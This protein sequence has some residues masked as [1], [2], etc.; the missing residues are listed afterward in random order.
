MKDITELIKFLT[1]KSN[2][3]VT[4]VVVALIVLFV[5][6][7]G[8]LVIEPPYV[9]FVYLVFLVGLAAGVFL[10]VGGALAAGAW[11]KEKLA[12]KWNA[13]AEDARALQNLGN[14]DYK[15]AEALYWIVK[16]EGQRFSAYTFNIHRELVAHGFLV[17][18]DPAT[19]FHEKTYL[20]VRQAI[21][22][23]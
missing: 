20:K 17:F 10:L 18:D 7:K 9:Y 3:L 19:E 15:H 21:G 22:T 1:D 12:A 6:V 23:R 11:G 13:G 4:I 5:F 8:W 14:I 2:M 16:K